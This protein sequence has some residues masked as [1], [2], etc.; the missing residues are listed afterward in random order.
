M[1]EPS[2]LTILDAW[3]FLSLVLLIDRL[4]GHIGI[5]VLS[6]V[7][8]IIAATRNFIARSGYI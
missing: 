6:M 1:E 4:H 3:V 2:L 8:L 7:A 5:Y